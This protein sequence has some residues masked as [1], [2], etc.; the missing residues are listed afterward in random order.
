MSSAGRC[1]WALEELGIPYERSRIHLDKGEQRK[2]EYLK[3]NPN[4]KVPALVD[5]DV[6]MFE[7]TAILMYLGEKYGVEKGLWPKAGTPEH[8]DALSWTMWSIAE[9]QPPVLDY[10]IHTSDAH[11]A[12]PKE[13]RNPATVARAKASWQR[14]LDI[15][16]G[17]LAGREFLAGSFGITDVAVSGV[18]GFG[19][20]G[21]LAVDA[22]PGV[23]AWTKRC[24]ARPAFGRA[25]AV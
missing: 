24:H 12:L 18:V 19:T 17:R 21:G 2:P 3:I 10:F 15:L 16:E 11:F 13:E 22:H 4:G 1:L 6:K 9:L 8:G 14:L 5:G 20:M 23:A 25:M 7:S